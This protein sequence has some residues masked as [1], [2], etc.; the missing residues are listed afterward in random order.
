MRQYDELFFTYHG[1]SSNAI[2]TY[3]SIC[4]NFGQKLIIANTLF[5]FTSLRTIK[6]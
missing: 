6:D 5:G 4:V 3:A 1:V 2:A